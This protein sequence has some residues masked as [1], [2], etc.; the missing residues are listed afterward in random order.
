MSLTCPV[1]LDVLMLRREIGAMYARV[2]T[3]PDGAFHF[4][5]GPAYATGM[6]G[7]DAQE[8]ERLP[9][10]VTARFAGVGNP[11]AI[12]PLPAGATVVDVGCGGGMDLLLAALHVGPTGRAI[13]VDMTAEMREQAQA[14][15]RG[16]ALTHVEVRDGD[17]TQLPVDDDSIDVV[18]SNG[19]LNLVPL[20]DRAIAEM[21]RVVKRGGRVQIADIVVG[22]ELP[23]SVRRDIDLWTG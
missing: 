13:G 8:L 22:E 6:L 1:D 21:A 10:D 11:H 3:A 7:Y 14:G 20:K 9:A 16:A 23:D 15:A 12:A 19:V 5:R 17:A 2:A 18:I 4:H